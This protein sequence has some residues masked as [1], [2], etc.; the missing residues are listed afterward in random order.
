M[1]ASNVSHEQVARIADGTASERAGSAGCTGTTQPFR[2]A[3]DAWLWTMA[4]FAG[5]AGR[6]PIHREPGPGEPAV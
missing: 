3:E 1:P 4:A 6:C 2:S 5:A